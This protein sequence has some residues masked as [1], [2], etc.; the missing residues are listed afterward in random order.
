MLHH[1]QTSLSELDLVPFQYQTQV[2]ESASGIDS[3]TEGGK[4]QCMTVCVVCLGAH[5]LHLYVYLY[6]FSREVM[7][8]AVSKVGRG[9]VWV[10][11]P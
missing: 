8:A 1:R 10:L 3:I 7:P 2:P 5:A 4:S 6:L 11:F 9:D